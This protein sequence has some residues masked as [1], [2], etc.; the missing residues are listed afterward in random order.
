MGRDG[1]G[2]VE[3]Y[4]RH[5]VPD[6]LDRDALWEVQLEVDRVEQGQRRSYRPFVRQTP[7]DIHGKSAEWKGEVRVMGRG[8]E[9]CSKGR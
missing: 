6:R 7:T 2:W 3:T 4:P 5:S 8:G 9:R 1:M